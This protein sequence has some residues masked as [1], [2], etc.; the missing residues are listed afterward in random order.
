MCKCDYGVCSQ[1]CVETPECRCHIG[2][3]ADVVAAVRAERQWWRNQLFELECKS[4]NCKSKKHTDVC[5]RRIARKLVAQR[6]L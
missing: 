1:A 2:P 3:S 4:P 6:P 5:I